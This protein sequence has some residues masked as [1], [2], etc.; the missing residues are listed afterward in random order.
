MS[1]IRKKFIHSN[2]GKCGLCATAVRRT[3]SLL[4][5]MRRWLIQ[6][7]HVPVNVSSF[8]VIAR[9]MPFTASVMIHTFDMIPISFLYIAFVCYD[10]F[11]AMVC[12]FFPKIGQ[13]CKSSMLC[14]FDIGYRFLPKQFSF[15]GKNNRAR[16]SFFLKILYD[17]INGLFGKIKRV[18]QS[19]C[20][21]P[22]SYCFA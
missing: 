11:D 13:G 6:I 20:V 16:P 18:A 7:K 3:S 8:S 4:K 17:C 9:P 19:F 12:I 15:F 22:S 21:A 10:T 5:G 14:L 1:K 2:E